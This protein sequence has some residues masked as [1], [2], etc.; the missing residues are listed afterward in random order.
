MKKMKIITI[1]LTIAITTAFLLTAQACTQT[2]ARSVTAENNADITT[3]IISDIKIAN[4]D[5]WLEFVRTYN[6]NS[7]G[8][9][10]YVYVSVDGVLDL[11]SQ[12]PQTSLGTEINKFNG[13]INFNDNQITYSAFLIGYADDVKITNANIAN[14][15]NNTSLV[16]NSSGNAVF[17]N[18]TVNSAI[19]RNSILIANGNNIEITDA[20][21]DNVIVY[22]FD[23]IGGLAGR[24]ENLNI[25]N[26]EI[27]YMTIIPQMNGG[28]YASGA[29]IASAADKISIENAA[30]NTSAV[31]A[32]SYASGL[33]TWCK[34]IDTKNTAYRNCTI[35]SYTGVGAAGLT[36]GI[37]VLES[38]TQEN[39]TFENVA[40][41]SNDAP[42]ATGFITSDINNKHNQN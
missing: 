19:F 40:L 32:K 13:E 3:A 2:E 20:Y 37:G 12:S 14:A 17:E 27:N 35:V 42:N 16:G 30:I 38:V 8:F 4:A 41:I 26:L 9:A 15:Q 6:E 33:A 24:C 5:E 29:L 36:A 10:D 39:L 21:M 22:G 31:T 25:R 7:G 23:E 1:I 34:E 28:V 11:T 18:I